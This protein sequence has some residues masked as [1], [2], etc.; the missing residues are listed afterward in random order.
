MDNKQILSVAT[1]IGYRLL[2]YGAEVYRAEQSAR[3]ICNS[4]GIDR[5]DV[6]AI[7]TSLVVTIEV[8]GDFI[9]KTKRILNNQVDLAKV[10]Q[11]NDLSR[12]IC[13]ETP[14]YEEITARLAEIETITHYP[15]PVQILANG[16]IAFG[17]AML[18]DATWAEGFVT[19]IIAMAAAVGQIHF[20]RWEHN[21][22]LR[23]AAASFL[24]S[25][26]VYLT[27]VLSG[28]ELSPQSMM[29]GGLMV[30][31]P[32]L[33]V[34]NCMRDFMANDYVAGLTKLAEALMTALAIALGVAVVLFSL[35]YFG[36]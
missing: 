26:L 23:T 3:F 8:D 29:A 13:N 5:A 32:G 7:P 9:T 36:G 15:I 14:D 17:F 21:R 16:C 24:I 1:E 34:T 31:V 33:T 27:V 19:F 4:Y 18:F 20:D 12:H 35:P 30:L 2:K 10:E 11:L 22:F 25:A 6:F 28:G